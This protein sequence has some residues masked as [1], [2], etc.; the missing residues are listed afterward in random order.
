MSQWLIYEHY[1]YKELRFYYKMDITNNNVGFLSNKEKKTFVE[2]DP[3][4]QY[5]D[6][7]MN[8]LGPNYMQMDDSNSP[9][10]NPEFLFLFKK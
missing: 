6:I 5:K 10:C 9:R 1:F 7:E 3:P 2:T 8:D 4:K